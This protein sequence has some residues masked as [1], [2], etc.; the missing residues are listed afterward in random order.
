MA[1]QQHPAQVPA[2]AENPHAHCFLASLDAT[3]GKVAWA[4]AFTGE[5]QLQAVHLPPAL[6]VQQ[7]RAIGAYVEFRAPAGPCLPS[8]C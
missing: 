2:Q 5:P 3:T 7:P 4:I 1:R 6:S 8:L